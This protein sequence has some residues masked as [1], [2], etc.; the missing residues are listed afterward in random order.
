MFR[1][2]QTQVVDVNRLLQ[3]T[4]DYG[5]A[6]AIRARISA[7]IT[8]AVTEKIQDDEEN[9]RSGKKM[10]E[11][12]TCLRPFEGTVSIQRLADAIG[13]EMPEA[14]LERLHECVPKVT[15][16]LDE[17]ERKEQ[18]EKE[19]KKEQERKEQERK[20]QE[21]NGDIEGTDTAIS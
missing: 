21:E 9:M 1:K 4:M 10:Y 7:I 6:Q 5:E 16:Y 11:W 15:A 14:T 2:G 3:Q 20:E 8:Q 19:A 18:K 13:Y 17:Q 12:S